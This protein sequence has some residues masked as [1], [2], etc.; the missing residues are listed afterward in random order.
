MSELRRVLIVPDTHI[1]Y[2]NRAAWNLLLDVA[3]RWKPHACVMLG[4]WV[5]FYSVSS[6]QKDPGKRNFK[7]EI[8]VANQELDRL[9]KAL[10][11][12]CDKIY[13]A[14]NH[15]NRLE[16][17]LL[18]KAPDLFGIVSVS[19][20]LNLEARG[21]E[22]VPY[23]KDFKIGKLFATHDVGSAGK[24]ATARAADAYQTHIV[25]GHTHRISY[26]V[27]G[28]IRGAPFVS[29]SLGWLGDWRSASY[30]YRVKATK[31]WALGFGICYLEADGTPHVRPVPILGGRVV[32][33]GKIY[34]G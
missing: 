32:I 22:W 2:H 19:G 33:G 11:A 12:D 21:W 27:Q 28:N 34:G 5:D 3:K 26:I 4:D 15:E 10:P 23:R 18:D 30:M 6:H 1:P 9:D 25:T 16:R 20:L 17:Y 31:D 8:A 29:A 13:I 24:Y 14:G 7:K